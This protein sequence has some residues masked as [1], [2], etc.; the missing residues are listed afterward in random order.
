MRKILIVALFASLGASSA[1]AQSDPSMT[2]ADYT[3]SMASMGG[4][5]KTGDAAMDAM[6][7]KM[8]DYCKANPAA[9]VS[10]AMEKAMQ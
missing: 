8:D 4:T 3:K 9:K 6:N 5:P 7:K 2:C 1:F 10:D